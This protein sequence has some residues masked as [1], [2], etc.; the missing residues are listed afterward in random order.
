MQ[1]IQS[2]AGQTVPDS[3]QAT[4]YYSPYQVGNISVTLSRSDAVFDVASAKMYAVGRASQDSGST[5]S[6][7]VGNQ[8]HFLV[9]LIS[10]SGVTLTQGTQL[11]AASC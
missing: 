9:K 2:F 6:M 3:F 4:L 7:V 1:G 5:V 10:T 11:S 8:A